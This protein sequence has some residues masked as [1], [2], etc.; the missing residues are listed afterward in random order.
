MSDFASG[1]NDRALHRYFIN[2]DVDVYDSLRDV[3]IGRLVNIHTQGLMLVGDVA[4]EE[5]K[6]YEL[7]L[8]LPDINTGDKVIRLGVDCLWT[9]SADQN[10]KHW[11]GFSIIDLTP[12]AAEDI[13]HLIEYWGEC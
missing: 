11:S 7:D 3:Y 2:G 1:S 6:L 8:H 12:D 9:R 13:R 10:G 4:L 5:D